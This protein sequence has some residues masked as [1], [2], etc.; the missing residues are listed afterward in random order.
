[1]HTT[2]CGAR[3]CNIHKAFRM[4]VPV[5]SDCA[6]DTLLS[7]QTRSLHRSRQQVKDAP[8][9]RK[10]AIM[11]AGAQERLGYIKLRDC[12]RNNRSLTL[13]YNLFV[14]RVHVA[15]VPMS[16]RVV[17]GMPHCKDAVRR[18]RFDDM[19][20]AVT[21]KHPSPT[22]LPDLVNMLVCVGHQAMIED[23]YIVDRSVPG[24]RGIVKT[25]GKRLC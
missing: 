8:D 19:D 20:L 14:N 21:C 6:E 3:L 13:R 1:M 7:A 23:G 11:H 4:D 10:I 15:I 25:P 22:Y 12:I 17:R 5:C 24:M 9:N 18:F 2:G 16:S